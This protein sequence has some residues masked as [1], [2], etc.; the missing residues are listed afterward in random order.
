MGHPK[1]TIHDCRRTFNS[2]A[3]EHG[4]TAEVVEVIIGYRR[5]GVNARHY[6]RYTLAAMHAAQAVLP[7]PREVA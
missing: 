2:L 6:T 4:A 1:Y 3:K 7:Y 5:G